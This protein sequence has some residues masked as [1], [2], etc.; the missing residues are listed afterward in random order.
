MQRLVCTI[1]TMYG[2]RVN[3]L[4]IFLY[5]FDTHST[6]APSQLCLCYGGII[7]RQKNNDEIASSVK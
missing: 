2:I 6:V 1:T 4:K 5:E 7:Y 3:L